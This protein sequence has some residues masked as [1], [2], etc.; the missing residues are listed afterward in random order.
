MRL[1]TKLTK[2]NELLATNERELKNAVHAT[3]CANPPEVTVV[4]GAST[5]M[6]ALSKLSLSKFLHELKN[7]RD[8]SSLPAVAQL[9]TKGL[10]VEVKGNEKGVD[11]D[12]SEVAIKQG[13]PLR[14][15]AARIVAVRG[16]GQY[17]VEFDYVTWGTKGEDG[18]V[19]NV[20]KTLRATQFR[21]L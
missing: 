9:I 4:K 12:W 5:L 7:Y 10:K 6:K 1:E 15:H 2:A 21:I 8:I 19:P 11:F 16:D 14:S 18:Y 20:H 17:E 13:S 3:L